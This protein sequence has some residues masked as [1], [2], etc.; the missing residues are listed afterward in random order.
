MFNEKPPMLGG[1]PAADLA[2][3]RDYLFRMSRGL[4]D[5]TVAVSTGNVAGSQAAS[6]GGAAKATIEKVRQNAEELKALIIKNATELQEQIEDGD[7]SVTS[8][9]DQQVNYYNSLYVAKS[10]YG[11]FTET[12]DSRITTTAQG[13]VESYDYDAMIQSNQD[14]IHLLQ[15]YLTSIDG[16]IRRGIVQDPDTGN[17]VTGIAIAQKLSF[18]GECGTDDPNHPEGDNYT[19]YYMTEGQTFGLY[20]STGWQFWIDGHK[21]GWFNSLDGMLHIAN[22]FIEQNLQFGSQWKIGYGIR[23]GELV[24]IGG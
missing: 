8:Y 5:V 17:Y 3:L 12:I 19:Y 11:T 14:S 10:E 4:E 18:T 9:V 1:N 7:A 21:K 13:V 15:N 20:T 24:Y 23:T 22:V 16:E 2:A 6:G